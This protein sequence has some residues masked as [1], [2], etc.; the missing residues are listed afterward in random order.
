MYVD[1]TS[2]DSVIEQLNNPV[3]RGLTN[4]ETVISMAVPG[5]IPL[6]QPSLL[7]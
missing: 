3:P 7:K 4:R 2:V 5:E 6:R 1:C